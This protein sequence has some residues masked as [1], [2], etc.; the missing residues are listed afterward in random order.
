MRYTRPTRGAVRLDDMKFDVEPLRADVSAFTPDDWVAM[1]NGSAWGQ[2]QVIKPDGEGGVEEH[3][4]LAKSPGLRGLIESFPAKCLDVSLARLGPGGRVSAHRDISGGTPMGVARFHV[5]VVTSPEVEFFVSERK[6]TMAPGETW[7]LD[8]SYLHRVANEGDVWRVHVIMDF[9]MNEAI[10][11]LLPKEDW[12]D[13][14]HKVHF[15]II[16]FFKGLELM[17]RDPRAFLRRLIS[18]IRLKFFGQSQMV[19]ED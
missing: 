12:V 18:V 19:F 9:E 11:S 7:N 13:Q 16:C 5:P 15:S 17:W 14:L 4:R 3:P 8:T 10:R 1:K 6:V 2:I